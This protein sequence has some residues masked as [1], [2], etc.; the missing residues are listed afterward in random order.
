MTGLCQT[1]VPPARTL[2]R[3]QTVRNSNVAG[4]RLA[5]QVLVGQAAIT[6]LAAL[7]FGLLQDPRAGVAAG[8]GGLVVL[9]PTLYVAVTVFVRGARAIG[10]QA[11]GVLYRAQ[12]GKWILV[13]LL[14][15]L[16]ALWFGENFLPLMLGCMACLAV[17]WLMLAITSSN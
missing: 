15:V 14:F 12:V 16:G 2:H 7:S 11:L 13:A 3:N 5:T 17:N 10:Q 6:L 4:R 8:F 9:L 1:A